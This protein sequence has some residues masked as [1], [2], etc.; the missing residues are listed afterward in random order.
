MAA[1]P[2]ASFHAIM[3]EHEVK[4]VRVHQEIV[5][6]AHMV[7]QSRQEPSPQPTGLT[8]GRTIEMDQAHSPKVLSHSLVKGSSF[9]QY[10]STPTSQ[11]KGV[12][13]QSAA[14]EEMSQGHTEP[15]RLKTYLVCE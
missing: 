6:R 7:R 5:A 13:A 4:P 11:K 10:H 3:S 8:G 12:H 2:N 15:T 9:R 14:R 1:G